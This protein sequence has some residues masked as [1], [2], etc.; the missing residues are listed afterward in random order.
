[1][2]LVTRCLACALPLLVAIPAV[3]DIAKIPSMANST[4]PCGLS[5]VGC[6]GG[7]ADPA[8]RFTIDIRDLA[9]NPISSAVVVVDF[10]ECCDDIRLADVQLGPG[11]Y[12]DAPS[13]TVRA[14]TGMDG[15]VTFCIMGAARG[16]VAGSG[17]G[18]KIYADGVLM[19]P[20]FAGTPHAPLSVSAFDLDGAAGGSAV[21]VGP[22]DLAV[23]LADMF[24]GYRARSDYDA[25]DAGCAATLTP[26]DLS[27][28]LQVYFDAGS[29]S[30]A[31][32][33]ACP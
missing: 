32:V 28:W 2:K 26:A 24:T 1:M 17:R 27:R 10:S 30:N 22:S 5:L 19:T 25:A 14:F 29:G 7:A 4:I 18:A 20:D 21:G 12:L 33:I 13:R 8:G 3:A 31:P 23:L 11:M 9:N 16:T 6:S 15:S